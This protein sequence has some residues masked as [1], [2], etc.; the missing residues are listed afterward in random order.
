M[1]YAS[2]SHAH[3]PTTLQIFLSVFGDIKT[4]MAQRRS[5]RQTVNALSH[6]SDHELSDLGLSRHSVHSD[7]WQAVYGTRPRG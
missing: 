3:R 5:Y 1:S 2:H 7:A 4:R 6:L